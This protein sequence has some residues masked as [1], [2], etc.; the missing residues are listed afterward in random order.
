MVQ[1]VITTREFRMGQ[2]AAW[3]DFDVDP[4]MTPNPELGQRLG[5]EFWAGYV[6][7]YENFIVPVKNG[8][9]RGDR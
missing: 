1:H 2:R 6:D 5:A 4:E 9:P 3:R 8:A 7:E